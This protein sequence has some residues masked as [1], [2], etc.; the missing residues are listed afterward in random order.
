MG[1]NEE[2]L[3]SWE[4][5]GDG[6]NNAFFFVVDKIIDLQSYFILYAKGVGRVVFLIAICS[7]ALNYALTGTGLK[8]NLIKIF[9]ATAFFLIV[10]QLYPNIIGYITKMTFEMADESIGSAVQTY[11]NE[12]ENKL[13]YIST[14]SIEWTETGSGNHGYGK[15]V[16]KIEGMIKEALRDDKRLFSDLAV[17]HLNPLMSYTAVAPA[18][19]LKILLLIAGDMINFADTKY[20]F[21]PEF[22]RVLKGLICA[23]FVIATGCFALLEYLVCFLEFML[24]TSV[25]V[26]LFPLS[27]W[28]GSKFMAEK[29]IG[30]IV[31]FFIKM[32]FCNIAIFLMI[33]GFITLYYTSYG[34][35][36]FQGLVDQII[37][38]VF[39]CLLF[40]YICKSAPALAQSL[41]TGSPSLSGTGAISAAAGAVGGA[42]AVGGFAKSAA[43]KIGSTVV[44]GSAKGLLAA[45]GSFSEA[46]AAKSSAM[47]DV[48][49]AGGTVK[50]QRQAGNSAFRSSIAGDVG[51]SLSA[52]GLGLARRLLGD[53]S[54]GQRG[55]GGGT[56]PH[57]W[58]QDFLNTQS[59]ET[60]GSQTFNE[61]FDKRKTEGAGRGK[62]SAKKYIS[63]N[64]PLSDPDY[65]SSYND[66]DK[67]FPGAG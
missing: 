2:A 64:Q 50:Q 56:N 20:N 13:E 57:S 21:L 15:K 27:I 4:L 6:L 38:V 43:G 10:I 54:G 63:K 58:R 16:T 67:E 29:F 36:G 47:D 39:V 51:D 40:F 59:K 7:A 44:G 8:E 12:T 55:S 49:Q 34:N 45:A 26:I 30:A 25:G 41:L 24:V 3:K 42:L 35:N 32:L 17:Y 53:T 52:A 33:Y 61:H 48:R 62:E 65:V 18:N 14:S 31:G 37:Y 5:F 19:T 11:F 46:G 1:N 22:S 28:E 60:D 9:K 23:G 66:L